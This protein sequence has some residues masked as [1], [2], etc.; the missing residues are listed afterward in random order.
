MKQ[1]NLRNVSQFVAL[2]QEFTGSNLKGRKSASESV[3]QLPQKY[4]DDYQDARECDDF[5]VVK[6]YDTPIAW[7][8]DHTWHVPNVRYS[9][10]TSRQ[11]SALHLVRNGEV[12][13][14]RSRDYAY[15]GG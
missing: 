8:A 12:W 4:Y 6:S 7:F 3:G 13:S 2:R 1:A 5:Y 10:S 11:Q 9:A 14:D 15:Q